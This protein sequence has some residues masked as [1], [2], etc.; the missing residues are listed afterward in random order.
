M[1]SAHQLITPL[2]PMLAIAD[3][4]SLHLLE[5]LTRRNLDN[6][7]ERLGGSFKKGCTPPIEQIN[8]ELTRYFQGGLTTF[9][10]PIKTAGTDFQ[11]LTWQALMA[12]PYGQRWSYQQQAAYMDMPK[13]VR[14]VA[15]A[16]GQNRFAIVI[17]CHRVI[18]NDGSLG[19]YGG[20]LDKK[21]A[22]LALERQ[23]HHLGNRAKGTLQKKPCSSH[24]DP[25]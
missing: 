3:E 12:I 19:G 16:N 11:Q 14:A 24:P 5:F 9:A 2:G 15:N 20:G 22:L 10:T 17:P 1:L 4:T 21:K 23:W 7:L 18:R 6:A 25:A 8:D 13:A